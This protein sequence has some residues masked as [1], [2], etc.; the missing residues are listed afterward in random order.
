MRRGSAGHNSGVT[1]PPVLHATK[2]VHHWLPLLSTPRPYAAGSVRRWVPAPSAPYPAKPLRQAP[3]LAES[4]HHRIQHAVEP[5]RRRVS[6]PPGS[7]VGSLVIA[8]WVLSH[9]GTGMTQRSTFR[10]FRDGNAGTFSFPQC[11]NA[12]KMPFLVP[13]SSIRRSG[14]F[15]DY[16]WVM[17]RRL[18]AP[19]SPC[20]AGSVGPDCRRFLPLL[21]LHAVDGRREVGS[22][23]D[24]DKR[25]RSEEN[26]NT[27]AFLI[28][29]GIW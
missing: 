14:N 12:S 24:E 13:G 8:E 29:L 1:T 2:L 27:L 23:G 17:R 10:L 19:S 18:H 28:S 6:A 4:M 26:L 5:G 3:H 21:A 16:G 11:K 25:E 20:V 9:C 22:L 15:G 7:R